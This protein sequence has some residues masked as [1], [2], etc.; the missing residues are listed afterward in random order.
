MNNRTYCDIIVAVLGC[1][2]LT[3]AYLAPTIASPNGP[4]AAVP[5]QPSN[6]GL[7][8]HP[9]Y[10][11]TLQWFQDR[12]RPYVTPYSNVEATE[13]AY[14]ADVM[15]FLRGIQ[16][17][18]QPV[19]PYLLKAFV[20]LGPD[21][22]RLFQIEWIGADRSIPKLEVIGRGAQVVASFEG[23]ADAVE[24]FTVGMG[25]GIHSV[26]LVPVFKGEQDAAVG[27]F[28]GSVKLHVDVSDMREIEGVR[29]IASDGS[30]PRFVR[31]TYG[32]AAFGTLYLPP[33]PPGVPPFPATR[34]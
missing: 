24:V 25:P 7:L 26:C 23:R 18:S 19:S 9:E 16:A 30:L 33:M 4:A 32:G 3:A 20:S 1:M 11:A 15:L 2:T 8:K 13:N 6:A 29:F 21:G 17:T 22:Q 14:A 12:Q 31:A 10:S 28:G 27:P 5:T 34:Q